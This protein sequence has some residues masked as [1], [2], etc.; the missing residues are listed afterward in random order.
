[1]T[2]IISITFAICF[3]ALHAQPTESREW[4]ST[5]GTSVQGRALAVI[6]GQVKLTRE[7]GKSITVPLN[8]FIVKDREFLEKHFGHTAITT[9]PKK[10]KGS[11]AATAQTL[12]FPLGKTSGPIEAGPQSHY[13]IYLPNSL[14]EGRKAP[15]IFFS[16]AGGGRAQSTHLFQEMAEIGGWVI[17]VS[18]ES[19]NK[20]NYARSLPACTTAIKHLL[21]TLPIDKTRI[22]FTG[23]SGG[24]AQ[25]LENTTKTR[26][27][28]VMPL[29]DLRRR[30]R[31]AGRRLH[32]II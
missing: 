10:P 9:E 15:L 20:L 2:R 23:G 31:Q 25:A 5:K 32:I 19:S 27:A 1:M 14:K 28:G 3:S 18:V 26:A 21:K 17:A 7:N 8:A 13:F 29:G 4:R 24:G 22:Y 30:A 12:P 11:G 16:N 6:D